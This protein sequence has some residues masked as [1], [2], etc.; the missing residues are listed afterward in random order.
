M[1]NRS[2][3]ASNPD[4]CALCNTNYV[5]GSCIPPRVTTTSS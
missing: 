1:P 5:R 3:V 2:S 4:S